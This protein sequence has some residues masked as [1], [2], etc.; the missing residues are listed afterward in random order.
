[1]QDEQP[2]AMTLNEEDVE[3]E[4]FKRGYDCE[5]NEDLKCYLL[6]STNVQ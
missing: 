5:L 1:M 4:C 6:M 3:L 2:T